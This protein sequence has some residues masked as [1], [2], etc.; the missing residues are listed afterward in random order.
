[1]FARLYKSVIKSDT[2][3][4]PSVAI[5]KSLLMQIV[6]MCWSVIRDVL[7]L[8]PTNRLV[9]LAKPL[10]KLFIGYTILFTE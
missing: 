4:S 2:W 10:V 6:D 9:S 3:S 1:M 8:N 5:Y 7:N